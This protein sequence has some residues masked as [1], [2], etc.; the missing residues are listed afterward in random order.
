MSQLLLYSQIWKSNISRPG[1]IAHCYPIYGMQGVKHS[2]IFLFT[3]KIPI[4][5]IFQG[6]SYFLVILPLILVFYGL[7]HHHYFMR[8]NSSNFFSLTFLSIKI[9]FVHIMLESIDPTNIPPLNYDYKRVTNTQ[10]GV[11]IELNPFNTI[12]VSVTSSSPGS[13]L[14]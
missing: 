10:E 11:V 7:F 12:G 8:E 4:F 3:D 9:L 5:P 2:Y 1:N 14:G 13:Y 6:N